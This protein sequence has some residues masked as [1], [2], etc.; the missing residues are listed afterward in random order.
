M[1]F[2]QLSLISI[3]LLLPAPLYQVA[4]N[5]AQLAQNDQKPII[6]NSFEPTYYNP[7]PFSK[8]STTSTS[9][10]V[11]CDFAPRPTG[12]ELGDMTPFPFNCSMFYLC[13]TFGPIIQTCPNG[14]V[15]DF[16]KVKCTPTNATICTGCCLK[17][18][19][20]PE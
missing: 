5:P 14:T 15:F 13:T 4:A 7:S 11:T 17:T 10:S 3:P 9:S 8:S 6:M 1:H 2:F 19:C 12:C 18:D 20:D 16:G